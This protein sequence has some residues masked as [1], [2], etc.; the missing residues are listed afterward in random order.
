MSDIDI[1][2]SGLPSGKG[3]ITFAIFAVVL[4]IVFLPQLIMGYKAE[5]PPAAA[6]TDS[7]QAGPSAKSDPTY[8][9]TLVPA[10]VSD[11]SPSPT[12]KP[13]P[14]PTMSP[15]ASFKEGNIVWFGNYEWRVLEVREDKA[16]LLSEY[17]T[18]F[19]AYHAEAFP[20]DE[21]MTEEKF[22]DRFYTTWAECDLRAY[23]NGPF[24]KAFGE[25]V[26]ARIVQTH[27]ENKDNQW[28]G[29]PGGEDT[30]DYI[31]LLSLEEVVKY[32]GDSRQLAYRPDD[33]IRY[34]SDPF[35]KLRIATTVVVSS[36]GRRAGSAM[37]WWLRSPGIDSGTAAE[38]NYGGVINVD[39]F[40]V[41]GGNSSAVR[42]AL[43]VIVD[44]ELD[45]AVG[46]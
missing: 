3:W 32:F 35:D 30:D 39:G 13:T 38:V 28:Y 36:Q 15:A 26:R 34:I 10:G 2:G 7:G 20:E 37:D 18:E 40:G 21:I 8:G 19:R 16:L 46:G 41:E 24:Y 25:D 4:G 9:Y 12:P 1:S 6:Q 5:Q 45:T 23:L 14:A 43:W 44:P 17:V 27:N 31:F 33:N 29:T 42:P 11:P 22:I